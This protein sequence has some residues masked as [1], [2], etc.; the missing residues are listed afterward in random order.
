MRYSIAYTP[1]ARDG[2]AEAGANWLGRNFFSGEPVEHPFLPGLGAHEIAYHTALP[3]REGFRACLKA[4]FRLRDE[5]TEA[6]LLRALMHFAGTIEPFTLPPL[7][8]AR[9]GEFLGLSPI[10]PSAEMD[11]LAALVLQVFDE[12][13]AP[14][15][16]DEIERMAP[17]RLSAPQFANLYRW[18]DPHVLDEFR[19]YLPLTGPLDGREAERLKAVAEAFFRPALE[20]PPHFSNLALLVEREPGAPFVV[21]SLHPMGRVSARKIA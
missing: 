21:H 16:E 17:E 11:R 6:Q 1:S 10:V 3:R 7:E 14:L 19:F 4:P 18:G 12:F 9:F 8:V 15:S 2:L 5:T 20:R 13:R